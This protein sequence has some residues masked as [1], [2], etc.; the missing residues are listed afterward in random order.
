V[1]AS[2][3]LQTRNSDFIGRTDQLKE[4]QE[5]LQT[6]KIVALVGLCSYGK[7]QSGYRAFAKKHLAV[8]D[9]ATPF[10]DV[11]DAVDMWI[12]EQTSC[13]LIYDNAE[14]YADKLPDF[15]PNGLHGAQILICSRVSIRKAAKSNTELLFRDEA[16]RFVQKQIENTSTEDAANLSHTLGDLP[17]VLE[18]AVALIN[19]RK[20]SIK[21]HMK[22]FDKQKLRILDKNLI[23]RIRQFAQFE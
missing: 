5:E 15:L 11:K 2:H 4:I 16:V 19:K 12:S 1:F 21:Q 8:K 22:E 3:N 10:E 17:L 14:G 20:H 18:C 9:K 7:T 6:S 23:I 13:L